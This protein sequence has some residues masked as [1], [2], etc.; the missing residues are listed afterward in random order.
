[1]HAVLLSQFGG[2]ESLVPCEQ[3][4]PPAA[5]GEVIV[6]LQAAA[7][8]W[9]DCLLRGGQY[10]QVPVPHVIGA[11]GAG[12]LLDGG[13]PV[14]ILPSLH[15]GPDE[16]APGSDWEILGDY[17]DGTYAELVRIPSE[18]VR[19]LPAGWT[20]SEG[21]ALGLA[22]LTAFRA[23]FTRGGLARKETVLILGAGG[24]VASVAIGLAR[25]AGARV[26]VT[27][28]S[29]T[30]LSLARDMGAHDGVL[31]T[32]SDWPAQI[33]SLSADGVDLVLDSVGSTIGDAMSTLRAGGRLVSIGATGAAHAE[34]D[35]RRLYFGQWSLLGS[36]MGS[37]RDF[38]GLL[39]LLAENAAWRPHVDRSFALDDAAAAHAAMERHEHTGKLVLEIA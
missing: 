6:R 28:S 1:V 20:P 32:D 39:H 16:H 13:E 31:Y 37:P 25:M 3:P 9:H 10:P 33:R 35:L 27:T 34:I 7:L 15:W 12:H 4:D 14:L 18:N 23:L 29:D 11:D 30:K 19:A 24:G 5:P 22:G 17:A 38:D 36:T 26:L 2:P 21:A 8:N